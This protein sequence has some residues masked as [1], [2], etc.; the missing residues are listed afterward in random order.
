M[1]KTTEKPP[2]TPVQIRVPINILAMIRKE[3]ATLDRTAS[4]FIVHILKKYYRE[5]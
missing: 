4:G 1:I 5:K 3:A 2:T